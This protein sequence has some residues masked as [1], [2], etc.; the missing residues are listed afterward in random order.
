MKEEMAKDLS[1]KIRWLLALK[2]WRQVDLAREG[3][4]PPST[5]AK[6]LKKQ[7][8]RQTPSTPNYAHLSRLAELSGKQMEWWVGGEIPINNRSPGT[9]KEH[10]KSLAVIKSLEQILNCPICQPHRKIVLGFL[11]F[12]PTGNRRPKHRS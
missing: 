7:R 8:G 4:F 1:D 5:I 10:A 2:D 6:W 3:G 11:G 9:P 12:K